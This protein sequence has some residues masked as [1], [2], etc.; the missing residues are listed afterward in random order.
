[1]TQWLSVEPFDPA[2]PAVDPD[3]TTLNLM[4]LRIDDQINMNALKEGI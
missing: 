4:H 1:M 3:T 2:S